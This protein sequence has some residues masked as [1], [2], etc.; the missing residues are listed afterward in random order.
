LVELAF[1]WYEELS[2]EEKKLLKTTL[3][4]IRSLKWTS[5]KLRHKINRE[6]NNFK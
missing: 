2:D 4:V 1:D 3:V 5:Q 6:I